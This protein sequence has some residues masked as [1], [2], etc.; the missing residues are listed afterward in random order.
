MILMQVDPQNFTVE[1]TADREGLLLL[2]RHLDWLL[3]ERNTH[4]HLM[5]PSWGGD[6]LSDGNGEAGIVHMITISSSEEASKTG[7]TTAG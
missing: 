2:R 1:V 3:E 6:D 7:K 5:S 4:Y